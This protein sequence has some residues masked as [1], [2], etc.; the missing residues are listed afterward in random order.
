MFDHLDDPAGF[1]PDDDFRQG[2]YR[3]GRRI[4][5]AHRAAVVAGGLAATVA[6]V[7]LAG[8]LY[9]DRRDS[10]IDRVE[11]E[12][13]PSVDGA[14]NILLIGTD[15]GTVGRED[16]EGVRADTMV[17][18]RLDPDGSVGLLSLPR[19]LWTADGQRLNSYREESP[20]ALITAV[21]E[22]T[23]VPVDH[24]IEID[25]DGLVALVD[26][27]GGL[28]LTIN[29]PLVD[30]LSGLHLEPEHCAHLDGETALA[31]LRARHVDDLSEISRMG[32][33]RAVLS[34]A[35]FELSRASGD[36]ERID[37]V[38]RILADHAALDDGLTLDRLADVAGE[39][40]LRYQ[41]T[42]TVDSPDL[43]LVDVVAGESA[44]T[45]LGLTP[46]SLGVLQQFGTPADFRIPEL[47]GDGSGGTGGT[48]PVTVPGTDPAVVA[49]APMAG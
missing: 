34:A 13:P 46:A 28:P 3:K 39:L 40:A 9:V 10:A 30:D 15:A 29:E 27:A 12:A 2:V 11:V 7:G 41:E 49:C 47:P 43:P 18:V 8:N 4:R 17:V 20:Q 37:R 1:V 23:G 22:T 14:V 24:Y 26:E 35:L 38:T 5:R 36:V 45:Y 6:V 25:M 19:D 33:G 48:N 16:V 31:L 21:T 42:G 44:A 32:R